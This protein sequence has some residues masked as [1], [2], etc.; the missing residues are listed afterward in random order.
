[1]H[2]QLQAKAKGSKPAASAG[3]EDGTAAWQALQAQALH[4]LEGVAQALWGHPL[5][6]GSQ[7][8]ERLGGT[9]AAAA[10]AAAPPTPIA[11]GLS[12]LIDRQQADKVRQRV[13]AVN[14]AFLRECSCWCMSVH[15]P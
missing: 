3:A 12:T 13:S 9:A 11:L 6:R 2:M 4:T 7:G 10:P 1:M 14:D 8:P 15:A 5:P